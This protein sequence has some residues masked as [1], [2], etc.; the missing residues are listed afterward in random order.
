MQKLKITTLMLLSCLY[1][2][3]QK[4]KEDDQYQ[5]YGDGIAEATALGN[6]ISFKTGASMWKQ[7]NISLSLA[8]YDYGIRRLELHMINLPK[9]TDTTFFD[10]TTTQEEPATFL[11]VVKEDHAL[12]LYRRIDYPNT[13]SFV[14][15]TK[16]DTV[17]QEME[18]VFQL[19]YGIEK[20]FPKEDIFPD[21]LIFTEGRFSTKYKNY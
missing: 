21:T 11:D 6:K 15:I 8:Y 10:R 18:G 19:C 12:D 13:K 7:Q 1:F 4:N 16:L 20:G 5:P 3:C 2:S 9:S 17:K 14:V